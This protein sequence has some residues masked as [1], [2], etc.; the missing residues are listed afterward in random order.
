[1]V[2]DSDEFAVVLKPA[3]DKTESERPV[4]KVI[5]DAQSTP[6]DNGPELD[7][8]EKDD[9]G[10]YRHSIVRLIDNMEYK[11]DTSRYFL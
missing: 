1:V 10:A 7:L 3:A 6:V 4:V 9:I 2:L 11:F 8:T 5:T